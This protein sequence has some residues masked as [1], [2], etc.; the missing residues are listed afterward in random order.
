VRG[1]NRIGVS[2]FRRVGE[3][4]S[5]NGVLSAVGEPF[6][7]LLGGEGERVGVSPFGVSA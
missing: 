6:P 7:V 5:A 1:E 4:V 3:S 2:A